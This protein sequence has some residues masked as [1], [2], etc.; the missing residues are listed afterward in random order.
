VSLSPGNSKDSRKIQ[1]SWKWLWKQCSGSY[2]YCTAI[3]TS[4][5][6][7]NS[8]FY[9]NEKQH[10]NI[11]ILE[12][13]L[14]HL[15]MHTKDSEWN[16]QGLTG[17]NCFSSTPYNGTVSY[18]YS[19]CIFLLFSFSLVLLQ[20][21]NTNFEI[22]TYTHAHTTQILKETKQSS[23]GMKRVPKIYNSER[24]FFPLDN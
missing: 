21:S 13:S 24:K 11:N 15:C 19:S 17:I 23:K 6:W 14:A 12:N 8:L 7:P 10:W 2:I 20:I 22:A 9:Y 1:M 3:M 18:K 4:V 16:G 5:W